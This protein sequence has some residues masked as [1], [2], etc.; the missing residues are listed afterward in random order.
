[1]RVGTSTLGQAAREELPL[2]WRVRTA[3]WRLARRLSRLLWVRGSVNA[4]GTAAAGD[5]RHGPDGPIFWLD[6]QRLHSLSDYGRDVM[7][8]ISGWAAAELP[9][10][11]KDMGKHWQ[12]ADLLPDSSSPDFFDQTQGVHTQK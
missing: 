9:K 4:S 5:F 2:L 6:R 12:P 1:M 7:R 8:S 3:V 10:Y 11:L